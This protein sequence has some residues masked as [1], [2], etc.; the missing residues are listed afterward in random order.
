LY[1]TFPQHYPN[2]PPDFR[3]VDVPYHPNVSSEGKL[4]FTLLRRDCAPDRRVVDLIIAT[5]NLLGELEAKVSLNKNIREQFL[6]KRDEYE[7]KA[8]GSAVGHGKKAIAD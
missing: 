4:L 8:A 5:R 1:I 3:F 6:S 2:R 7:T